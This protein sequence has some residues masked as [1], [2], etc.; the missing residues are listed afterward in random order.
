[1]SK[2]EEIRA[3]DNET[4]IIFLSAKSM[5]EDRIKGFYLGADDFLSKPFST[6]EL[7]LRVDA[8]LKRT[9]NNLLKNSQQLLHKIGKFQFDYRNH[10]L[11]GPDSER[12]LTKKEADVLQMLCL[13]MN[14]T[15]RRDIALVTI[16]GENDYF[17]G[18]SMDVYITKL[19]KMLKG[20]PGISI[21]NIHNVGFKLEV[22]SKSA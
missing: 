6:K 12:K 14:N 21:K 1:M 19:R 13:N 16:W 4:P 7:K 8:I 11:K 3:M 22:L 2:I 17:M 15:L 20:D 5:Q 9:R 10:I 18:R